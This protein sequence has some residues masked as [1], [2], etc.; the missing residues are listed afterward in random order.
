MGVQLSLAR[1]PALQA[2]GQEFDSPY[3]HQLIFNIRIAY[4]KQ[5]MQGRRG[6]ICEIIHMYIEQIMTKSDTAVRSL[7]YAM[8]Y[9]EKYID[10]Y[11]EI[12]VNQHTKVCTI[13]PKQSCKVAKLNND[14]QL[15]ERLSY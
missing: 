11:D 2:G 3:L 9:I 4:Y 15:T 1:A 14:G 8:K 13:E 7:E 5:V 6:G 10:K 12:K